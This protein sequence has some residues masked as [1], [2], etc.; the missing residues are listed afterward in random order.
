MI[1]NDLYYKVKG[2][3]FCAVLGKEKNLI[4]SD[5]RPKVIIQNNVSN[6]HL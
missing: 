3:I 5:K 1:I 6:K 2:Y 4:K